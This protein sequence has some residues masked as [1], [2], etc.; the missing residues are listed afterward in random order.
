M[1]FNER[2]ER[3]ERVLITTLTKKMSEDL[4]D[5]LKEMGIKVAIFTF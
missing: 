1:K 4:T 2:V 5:Y 3:N